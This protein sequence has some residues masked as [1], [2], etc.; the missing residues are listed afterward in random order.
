MASFQNLMYINTSSDYP[1]YLAYRFAGPSFD[2]IVPALSVFIPGYFGVI[3]NSFVVFTTFRAKNLR[4]GSANVLM[5]LICLF[6]VGHQCG[7]IVFLVIVASGINFIGLFKTELLLAPMLFCAN[8]IIMAMFCASADRLF[9]V[10][11]PFKH[12][13]ITTKHYL[14]YLFA[15]TVTCVLFGL[16]SLYFLLYNAILSSGKPTTGCICEILSDDSVRN[17][18]FFFS[19][20]LN[21]ACIV[22][23]VAIGAIIKYK[24]GVTKDTNNRLMR[25]LVIILLVNV[26]G[27]LINLSVYQLAF[28]FQQQL[29]S[30]VRVWQFTFISASLLNIC[31]AAN[32]PI[33]FVNST[34]YRSEFKREFGVIKKLLR[35]G[36]TTTVP[37]ISATVVHVR[38]QQQFRSQHSQTIVRAGH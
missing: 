29:G 1:L 34:D 17:Q 18:Y 22:C 11:F 37:I 31:S 38:Q 25:S 30:Y 19:T 32:A 6:E 26:G 8:A 10:L 4:N 2:L 24:K 27:Y 23:Y 36:N 5:A 13:S 28:S 15:H 35:I 3:L 9:A 7:H 21:L 14:V 16:Y 20:L 33:L 12:K